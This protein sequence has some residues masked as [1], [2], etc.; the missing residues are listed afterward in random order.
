MPAETMHEPTAPS[1]RSDEHDKVA[2]LQRE[3]E[4]AQFDAQQNQGNSRHANCD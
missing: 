3:L 1:I 2:K 4:K